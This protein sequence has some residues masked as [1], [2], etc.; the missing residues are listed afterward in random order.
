MWTS[1]GL[2]LL[3]NFF[4][5]A[6]KIEEDLIV[7]IAKSFY[8]INCVQAKYDGQGCEEALSV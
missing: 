8:L 5:L 1:D 3:Y 2:H 6:L 4:P 7:L